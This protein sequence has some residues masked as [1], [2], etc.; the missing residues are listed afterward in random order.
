L[1][2]NLGDRVVFFGVYREN[3]ITLRF[4]IYRYVFDQILD[5]ETGLLRARFLDHVY[6]IK[7]S[8]PKSK[9]YYHVIF[10]PKF[11]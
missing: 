2:L 11:P 7:V 9:Y 8:T 3:E 1:A 5:K 10:E 4:K 6:V